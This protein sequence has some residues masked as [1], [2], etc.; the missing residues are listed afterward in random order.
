M[1]WDCGRK[2][3]ILGEQTNRIEPNRTG[4]YEVT[5]A[6]TEI[7]VAVCLPEK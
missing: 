4:T 5:G 3:E 2:L 1:I 7:E 6:T